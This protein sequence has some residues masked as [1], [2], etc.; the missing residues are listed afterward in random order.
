MRQIT[1]KK[2]R[3]K[4]K[5]WGD[6][7]SLNCFRKFLDEHLVCVTSPNL[8]SD[9]DGFHAYSTVEVADE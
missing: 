7:E 3:L 4:I 1:M 9:Q 5:F 2:H 8:P 6:E